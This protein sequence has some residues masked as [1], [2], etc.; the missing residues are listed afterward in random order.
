MSNN[1]NNTDPMILCKSARQGQNKTGNLYVAVNFTPEEAQNLLIAIDKS[2]HETRGLQ[3]MVNF[4]KREDK[5]G[6][7]FDGA[8]VFVREVPEYKGQGAGAPTRAAQGAPS[9]ASRLAALRQGR[10]SK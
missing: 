1:N 4:S 5:Q 10:A 3:L 9:G 8:V 6:R 2:I 7:S